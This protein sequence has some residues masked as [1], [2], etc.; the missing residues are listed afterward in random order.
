MSEVVFAYL[1]EHVKIIVYVYTTK[2]RIQRK[3]FPGSLGK[4]GRLVAT[5]KKISEKSYRESLTTPFA[6]LL[7]PLKYSHRHL[8]NPFSLAAIE[9]KTMRLNFLCISF[10]FI[11]TAVLE[12]GWDVQALA[13]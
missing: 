12:R 2:P 5:T 10:T 7:D 1:Y 8:G 3:E 13:D 4:V 11:C 6:V 9:A